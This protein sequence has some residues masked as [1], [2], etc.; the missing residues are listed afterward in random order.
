MLLPLVVVLEV[1]DHQVLV[2]TVVVVV[3]VVSKQERY[4]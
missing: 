3:L 4:L 1:G 2:P